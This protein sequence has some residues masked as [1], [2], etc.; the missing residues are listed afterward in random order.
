ME[1]PTRDRARTVPICIDCGAEAIKG[2]DIVPDDETV[3]R[4]AFCAFGDGWRW[5]KTRDRFVRS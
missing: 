1:P 2:G 4:W 3:R 5:C